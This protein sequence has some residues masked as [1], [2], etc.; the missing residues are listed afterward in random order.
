MVNASHCAP[1]PGAVVRLRTPQHAR[2]LSLTH[3]LT[4]FKQKSLTHSRTWQ[5]L[6][7]E[8]TLDDFLSV[9]ARETKGTAALLMLRGLLR[10][11]LEASLALCGLVWDADV[12]VVIEGAQ[13][14]LDEAQTSSCGMRVVLTSSIPLVPF[15]PD[16]AGH[17]GA[18]AS[19]LRHGTSGRA[20]QDDRRASVV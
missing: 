4:H 5:V 2:V 10:Q 7:G 14:S 20:P 13:V 17:C 16:I 18:C 11:K 6:K 12:P 15:H 3:T 8:R 19:T 9:L 1:G